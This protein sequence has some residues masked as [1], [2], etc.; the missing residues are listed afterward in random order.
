MQGGGFVQV[1]TTIFDALCKTRRLL[2]KN[3]LM[4]PSEL[5]DVVYGQP[6]PDLP[7]TID[8][9]MRLL[10]EHLWQ[11][12]HCQD[13]NVHASGDQNSSNYLSNH[14]CSCRLM[15]PCL[16]IYRRSLDHYVIAS[17]D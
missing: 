3:I 12:G 15:C 17:R 9:L 8:S 2:P 1:S 16:G 13:H 5:D 4:L 10:C 6:Y 7:Q 14:G 11:L